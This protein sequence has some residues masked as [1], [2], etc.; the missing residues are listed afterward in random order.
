MTN[1][2][3]IGTGNVFSTIPKTCSGFNGR[4][5]NKSSNGPYQPSHKI[6]ELFKFSGHHNFSNVCEDSVLGG[7]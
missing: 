2:E 4:T 1:F 6:V 7:F 5:V 3:A